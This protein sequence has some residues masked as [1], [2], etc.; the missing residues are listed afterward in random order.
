MATDVTNGKGGIIDVTATAQLINIVPVVGTDGH[1]KSAMTVKV[2]NEGSTTIYAVVNADASD[3]GEG[4]AFYVEADAIPIAP[5]KDFW[6]VGQ[7][8]KK[9]VLACATGDTSTANYGA[10]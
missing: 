1:R 7:P 2:S 10:Y 5:D 8:I 9:L 4:G 6:F 3:Q